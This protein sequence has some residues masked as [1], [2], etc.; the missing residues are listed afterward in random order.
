MGRTVFTNGFRRSALVLAGIGVLMGVPTPAPAEVAQIVTSDA[1]V[2]AQGTIGNLTYPDGSTRLLSVVLAIPQGKVTASPA[3]RG[4]D[5]GRPWATV[6]ETIV[7]DPAAGHAGDGTQVCSTASNPQRFE[8]G[9]LTG[10]SWV[11]TSVDVTCDDGAGYQFY[12]ILWD[13]GPYWLVSNQVT[14]ASMGSQLTSW[15]SSSLRGTVELWPQA[16]QQAKVTVCGYRP[17][18]TH[19]NCFG[20]GEGLVIP[21]T[22]R[23]VVQAIGA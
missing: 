21:S 23:M 13:K 15:S 8:P 17:G 5:L 11:G 16:N 22:N 7:S 14:A 4:V 20:P 2:F 9:A 12:R 10:D 18:T 3:V 19:P 1:A 6:S